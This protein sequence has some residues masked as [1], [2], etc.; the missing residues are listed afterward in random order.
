MRMTPKPKRYGFR[1]NGLV[2]SGVELSAEDLIL[3]DFP[4]RTLRCGAVRVVD[5][6]SVPKNTTSSLRQESFSMGVAWNCN[7]AEAS[8]LARQ[9]RSCWR[10]W[11]AWVLDLD[12][13]WMI[14]AR[15]KDWRLVE[16][17][18]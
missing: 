15:E 9:R 11:S 1:T 2:S 8:C 17:V 14:W 5:P 7:T 3:C 4:T 16:V 6:A 18:M 13:V 12:M 10:N